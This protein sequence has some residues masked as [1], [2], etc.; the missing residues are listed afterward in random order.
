MIKELIKT[1]KIIEK[2]IEKNTLKIMYKGIKFSYIL[3]IISCLILT[4]Y[5]LNPITYI[6]LESG[7]ILFK[8]SLIYAFCFILC[9]IFVSIM[10]NDI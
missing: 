6:I 5:L 4:F 10:K 7:I 2:K 8:N 9:G 1:I 3:A